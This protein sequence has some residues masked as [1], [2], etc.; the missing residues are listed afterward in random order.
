MEDEKIDQVSRDIIAKSK[1]TIITPDFNRLLMYK[2]Y[3][4]RQKQDNSYQRAVYFLAFLFTDAII[5]ISLKL[6]NIPVYNLP[7]FV[8]NGLVEFFEILFKWS[9]TLFANEISLYTIILF[10]VLLILNKILTMDFKY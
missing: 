10:A 4:E 3:L 8:R 7:T 2:I 9:D 6:Y 1:M 5:Y